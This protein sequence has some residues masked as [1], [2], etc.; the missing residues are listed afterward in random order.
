MSTLYVDLTENISTP[1]AAETFADLTTQT[2]LE[3]GVIKD[4][5]KFKHR[6][7]KIEKVVDNLAQMQKTARKTIHNNLEGFLNITRLHN[8]ALHDKK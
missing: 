8:K 3:H 7:C 2:L 6:K 4:H 5:P 1:D